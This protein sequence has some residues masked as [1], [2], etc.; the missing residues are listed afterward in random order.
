MI[1]RVNERAVTDQDPL[2]EALGRR[3]TTDEGLTDHTVVAYWPGLDFYTL[4]DEQ[5]AWTSAQ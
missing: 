5:A 2:G 3:V 1:P 4:D